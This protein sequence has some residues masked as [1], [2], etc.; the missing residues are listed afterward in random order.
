MCFRC[1]SRAHRS[2]VR[3]RP[4][5]CREPGLHSSSLYPLPI[6]SLRTPQSGKR[7][8]GPIS[9]GL[10]IIQE[11]GSSTRQLTPSPLR[12]RVGVR[13]IDTDSISPCPTIERPWPISRPHCSTHGLHDTIAICII[14]CQEQSLVSTVYACALLVN[15]NHWLSTICVCA[16]LV[17]DKLKRPNAFRL[18]EN[19]AHQPNS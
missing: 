9:Q 19:Q 16:L 2:G 12:E 17:K 1:E 14:C 7:M 4:D 11:T 13:V 15:S 6:L 8:S 10:S 18:S 3:R 5:P